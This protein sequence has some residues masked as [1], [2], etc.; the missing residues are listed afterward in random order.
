MISL[1]LNTIYMLFGNGIFA[2]FQSLNLAVLAHIGGKE[3]VGMFS[4]GLAISAPVMIF[5][6]LGLRTLIST[7]A[8]TRYNLFHCQR[9]RQL[10]TVPG[11]LISLL[12][13]W[14]LAPDYTAFSVVIMVALSKAAENQSDLF[15][16]AMQRKEQHQYI[17]LSL[18]IRGGLGFLVLAV[19]Y[20][21]TKN[22]ILATMGYALCWLIAALWFDAFIV[23]RRCHSGETV[24]IAGGISL[25]DLHPI[26]M[27]G[28]P[29]GISALLVNTNMNLPR[30]VLGRTAGLGE[31]GIFA[32]M[33]YLL[34]MGNLVVNS[35][36]QAINPR[37]AYLYQ[38]GQITAFWHL[39]GRATLLALTLALLVIVSVSWWGQVILHTLYGAEFAVHHQMFTLLSFAAPFSHLNTLFGYVLTAT[40][41]NFY[42]LLVH[43]TGLLVTTLS[44]LIFIVPYGLDGIVWAVM[45]AVIAINMT[46]TLIF[47]WMLRYTLTKSV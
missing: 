31:L 13:G 4:L 30:L 32:S 3:P 27:A 11:L 16:G 1:R 25:G 7:D 18:I 34:L 40:H 43:I 22:V 28:L 42:L 47:M 17:A 24:K 6:N 9:L 41:K 23:R 2:I 36:G 39:A 8:H 44:C 35:V 33:A 12:L 46:Y 45:S 19:I 5:F 26:F 14:L 38:T 20:I 37:L 15:Y 21:L 10:A 29:L